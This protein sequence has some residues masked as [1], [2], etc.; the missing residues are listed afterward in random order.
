MV[1]GFRAFLDSEAPKV[2]E[3]A[4]SYHDNPQP[5][6]TFTKFRFTTKARK[7]PKGV[8]QVHALVPLSKFAFIIFTCFPPGLRLTKITQAGFEL[9]GICSK[10]PAW[11]SLPLLADGYAGEAPAGKS[12]ECLPAQRLRSAAPRSPLVAAASG[13]RFDLTAGLRN[14]NTPDLF[15]GGHSDS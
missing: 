9:P 10:K 2:S 11:Y 1:S 14:P 13:Q 8:G 12:S 4:F 15:R 6:Q 5:I 3:E 7:H